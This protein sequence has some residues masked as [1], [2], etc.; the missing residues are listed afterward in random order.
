MKDTEKEF[1][2]TS[3]SIDN[4]VVIYVATAIICLAGIMVYNGLPKE[5]FPE[6]VFPQIYVAT[7]YPGAAPSDVENLI[8]KQIEKQVKG[9]AGVRKITSN[10][11]QD[12]SNVIIE[13]ETD[14][15]VK[16]AKREVTEA[17]DKAKQDLPNDLPDDP[18]VVDIDISEV[19]IMNVN[20]SGDYDLQTLKKYAEQM[21][22]RMET[23]G[24]LRRVDIVGALDREIHRQFDAVLGSEDFGG[25]ETGDHGAAVGDE[26]DV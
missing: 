2:P 26:G 12:F 20:L 24:E 7:V 22:D 3:W 9:I 1:R 15:E 19:P 11:V 13:F 4:K 5:N 18:Q 17:V 10:S 25:L 21:Q 23:L 16:E 14:V 8:S 6:V